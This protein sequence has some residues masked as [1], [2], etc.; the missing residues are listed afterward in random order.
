MKTTFKPLEITGIPGKAEKLYRYSLRVAGVCTPKGSIQSVLFGF[1][2]PEW[3]RLFVHCLHQKGTH[4]A[5]NVV[6][7]SRIDDWN[8]WEVEIFMCPERLI[9]AGIQ[10][11]RQSEE[12]QQFE[13][14]LMEFY[15]E[16]H[17]E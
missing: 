13:Q 3:A 1:P 4:L 2:A 8:D 17:H 11:D 12:G 16:A 14:E 15:G 7:A 5:C 9:L 10:K 6:P